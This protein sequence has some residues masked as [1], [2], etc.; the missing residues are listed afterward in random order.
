MAFKEAL[1]KQREL[2]LK[3][4]SEADYLKTTK[5]AA[6]KAKD[7]RL[8]EKRSQRAV[9]QEQ[10]QARRQAMIAKERCSGVPTSTGGPPSRPP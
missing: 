3:Y 1:R 4:K 9:A 8:A 10:A 2:A 7:A 5:D 6:I